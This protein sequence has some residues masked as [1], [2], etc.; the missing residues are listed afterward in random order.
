MHPEN[1]EEKR[2]YVWREKT[3]EVKDVPV[4]NFAFAYLVKCP[5]IPECIDYRVTPSMPTQV[6]QKNKTYSCYNY[7]KIPA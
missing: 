7:I 2:N 5:G 3:V 4:E 1:L 6:K